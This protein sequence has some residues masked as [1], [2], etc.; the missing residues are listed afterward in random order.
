MEDVGLYDCPMPESFLDKIGLITSLAW[1]YYIA[2]VSRIIFAP[3]MSEIERD[4]GMSHTDAGTMFLFMSIG[5]LIGP[6]CSGFISSKIYHLGTLK[7]SAVFV[8]TGLLCCGFSTSKWSLVG[9]FM[10]IGFGGSLHLPSAIT[11]ITA[12]VQKADWG[13]GLSVHQCAP[14]L[15]FVSAPIIAAILLRWLSWREIVF[16]LA[17]LAFFSAFLYLIKGKGGEFPGQ[18]IGL[19][20]IKFVGSKRSFWLLV[21]IFSM[22]MS[23]NAGIF[24]ML[25]LYLVTEKGFDLGSANTLIGLSQI[26]GIFMVF[27]AGWFTDIFGMKRV[28]AVSLLLTGLLTVFI[29][30]TTGWSLI[31][32][33]FLQPA[34]LATFFPAGFAALSGVVPPNLRSVVNAL[35]PPIAFLVGGGLIPLFIGYSAEVYSMSIGIFAVGCFILMG[36]LLVPFIEVGKYDQQSGC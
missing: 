22:A 32:F 31:V 24:A 26:S 15:S 13:K 17:G 34:I 36:A 6:L 19:K 35:G 14:S 3:L 10:V 18:V 29:S 5:Y 4:L 16:I 7:M 23:G 8:G 9:G 30:F 33:L 11:T 28:I 2:F 25:P 1:L 27:L 12:E 21:A 20:N